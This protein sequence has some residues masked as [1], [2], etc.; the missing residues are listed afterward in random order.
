MRHTENTPFTGDK[1]DAPA[2]CA[3]PFRPY[4]R[5]VATRTQRVSEYMLVLALC[6]VWSSGNAISHINEVTLH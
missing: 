4:C 2:V 1:I 3:V 5:G 6:L